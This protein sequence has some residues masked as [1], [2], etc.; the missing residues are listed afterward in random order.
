MDTNEISDRLNKSLESMD[1]VDLQ[2]NG[3]LY[4]D[5][6]FGLEDLKKMV[7]CLESL[8]SQNT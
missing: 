2:E 8:K 6:F 4:I 3:T 1:C 7:S 5:G